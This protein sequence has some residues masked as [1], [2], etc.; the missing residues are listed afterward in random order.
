MHLLSLEIT[1]INAR[2]LVGL[3]PL[4][5]L[6]ETIQE[7]SDVFIGEILRRAGGKISEELNPRSVDD[8]ADTLLPKLVS[9]KLTNADERSTDGNRHLSDNI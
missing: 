6:L 3:T 7:T 4:D 1:D 9:R 5:V 2:N 8:A